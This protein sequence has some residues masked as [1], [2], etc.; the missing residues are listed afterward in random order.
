MNAH[1]PI[2]AQTLLGALATALPELEAAKKTSENAAFKSGGKV[3]KYAD[4]GSVIDAIRPI[5]APSQ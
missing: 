4:L 3:S 5:A 1:A 2:E